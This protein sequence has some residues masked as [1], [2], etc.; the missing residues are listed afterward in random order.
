MAS[1]T[2]VSVNFMH[3]S[4]HLACLCVAFLLLVE[5]S[6]C[7]ILQTFCPAWGNKKFIKVHSHPIVHNYCSCTCPCKP[8]LRSSFLKQSWSDS[9]VVSVTFMLHWTTTTWGQ[10][11]C[12]VV[13][14][15]VHRGGPQWSVTVIS[16]FSVC[17]EPPS[18]LCLMRSRCWIMAN[19]LIP[20][21]L[22][23]CWPWNVI[24]I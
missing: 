7:L 21:R 22:P 12:K 14:S 4:R 18:C 8:S 6:L 19:I 3:Y 13:C 5:F 15:V 9:A 23:G 24:V 17:V 16:S 1:E 10:T 11:E 2:T 20:I